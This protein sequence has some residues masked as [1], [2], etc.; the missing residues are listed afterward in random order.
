[1]HVSS[2]TLCAHCAIMLLTIMV[3]ISG[4]Y[5]TAADYPAKMCVSAESAVQTAS[6]FGANVSW[7]GGQ[8]GRTPQQR[9]RRFENLEKIGNYELTFALQ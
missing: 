2:A 9:N 1:M 3:P 7:L 6:F 5:L 4:R 8:Y